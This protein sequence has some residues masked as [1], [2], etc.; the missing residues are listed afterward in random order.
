MQ[1]DNLHLMTIKVG[2]S[3]RGQDLEEGVLRQCVHR[4]G[5]NQQAESEEGIMIDEI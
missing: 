3:G 5:Y 1:N 4:K 2:S